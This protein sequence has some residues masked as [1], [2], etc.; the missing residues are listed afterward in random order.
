MK[1]KTLAFRS[2]RLTR[3]TRGIAFCVAAA[4]SAGA[5]AA[6]KVTFLTSWYAQAEHGGF[7]QAVAKGIYQ[8]HGLDVTIKMGGPQVNGMQLLTSG[9]ADFLMGYDLQVLK[10]VEQGLPVTTVAASFQTDL[11]G[12]MTHEDVKGLA[13]LKNG[14][15]VLVS[16]SGRTTWWPWL[17]AKYGLSEAQ[18]RPYT[19]NLQP[20]M[21][22]ASLAQQAYPSSEL[23]Q[24]MKAGVKA[25]FYLF[26]SDGYPPY[27]TTI[28]AMDKTVKEKPDMVARFVRASMEGWKSYLADPAPA[29]ALIKQDNPNMKD[30]QIAYAID[31]LREFNFTGGGDAAKAGI[32]IMTEARWKKT[33]DFM[34]AQGLLKPETDWHK[35]FT[36]Q[37]V[38]DLKVM[39]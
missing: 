2:T 33:Y 24:A 6:D 22:D 13:D 16:T 35:A 28:V 1:D 30:D 23:F 7:Y 5:F 26:A 34:V 3:L 17:K 18:S 25:N 38:K 15:T 10:S 12:M 14:K 37:F 8:K 9:Q 32:G 4:A 19:F 39:P 31:K 29:N 36:T 11:Q 21:A 27:G 20:F